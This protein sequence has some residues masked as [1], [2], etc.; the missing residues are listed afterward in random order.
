MQRRISFGWKHLSALGPFDAI[1]YVGFCATCSECFCIFS[2]IV[3]H[4]WLATSN[5]YYARLKSGNASGEGMVVG[6]D[7]AERMDSASLF[8]QFT[9]WFMALEKGNLIHE[10]L[11]LIHL[12]RKNVIMSQSQEHEH[13]NVRELFIN[14]IKHL[15]MASVCSHS[16][17]NFHTH[18]L[19]YSVEIWIQNSFE[20]S[21]TMKFNRRY[22][23]VLRRQ[24][25]RFL[26][27]LKESK[28]QRTNTY[29]FR[30]S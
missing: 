22:S 3:F 21:S 23:F 4:R 1:I 10:I 19:A 28:S 8:V 16:H 13:R 9:T 15:S 5:E 24:Q 2:L 6:S 7:W 18:A 25:D 27:L 14:W 12:L 26:W 30:G 11:L 20:A 17:Q 29:S